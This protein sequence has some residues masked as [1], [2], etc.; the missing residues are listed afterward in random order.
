MTS[1][2]IVLN[3]ILLAM[4]ALRNV[5]SR[6]VSAKT[7][8]MNVSSHTAQA[9][10]VGSR[11]GWVMTS[12]RIAE[13][14]IEEGTIV[15]MN[16]ERM[17]GSRNVLGMFVERVAGN[18]SQGGDSSSQIAL[19]PVSQGTMSKPVLPSQILLGSSRKRRRPRGKAFPG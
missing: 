10:T 9:R 3:H 16:V 19:T 2:K 18:G 12:L 5:V 4:S 7:F 11:S 6:I 1:L 8:S 13:S 17:V 14:H 15:G